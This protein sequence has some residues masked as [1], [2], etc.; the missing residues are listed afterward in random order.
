MIPTPVIKL[1]ALHY[2]HTDMEVQPMYLSVKVNE[3][4]VMVAKGWVTYPKGD[5]PS[6]RVIAVIAGYLEVF[7]TLTEE[8]KVMIKTLTLFSRNLPDGITIWIKG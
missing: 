3:Y 2:P 1:V 5:N 8:N 6:T 7:N 4:D